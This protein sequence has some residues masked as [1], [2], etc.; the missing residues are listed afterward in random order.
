MEKALRIL[1][2]A[3]YVAVL[4]ALWAI[5]HP[6]GSLLWLGV[7]YV[8]AIWMLAGWITF[9]SYLISSWAHFSDVVATSFVASSH[10]MWLVPGA[11]ALSARSPFLLAVGVAIIV[12]ATRLMAVSRPP[13]G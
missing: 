11:L 8:L 2:S 5:F 7:A 12:N 3:V 1:P 9:G 6:A 4:V 10:A 13:R